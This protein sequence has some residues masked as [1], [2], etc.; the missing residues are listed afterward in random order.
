MHFFWSSRWQRQLYVWW[1]VRLVTVTLYLLNVT[2]QRH[3][4]FIW[5]VFTP[6][7]LYEGAHVLVLCALTLYMWGIEKVCTLL[8]VT[9]RFE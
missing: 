1:C 5:S 6:K 8:E 4:L 2:W 9:Y 3:H 7:L